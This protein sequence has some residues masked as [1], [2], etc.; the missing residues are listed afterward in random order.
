MLEVTWIGLYQLGVPFGLCWKWSEGGGWLTGVVDKEGEFTGD[1]I[2]FV[3][4][5]LKTALVGQYVRG[6]A[7][8][9]YPGTLSHVEIPEHG[10]AHPRFQTR[11]M[12]PVSHSISTMTSVG[13]CPLVRDPYEM[14]LCEVRFSA[15]PGGGE[16]LFAVRN[17]NKG[18]VVAFYNGVK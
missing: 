9:V 1:D 12:S 4:P 13:P 15:V 6:V 8:S 10:V 3:Y 7:M 14:T 5:D 11:A 16:G 2:A 17:I 18:E